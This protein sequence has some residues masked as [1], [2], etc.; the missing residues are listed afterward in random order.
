MIVVK[1]L[2]LKVVL[3]VL[4]LLGSVAIM[5]MLTAPDVSAGSGCTV[6]GALITDTTWSPSV[7]AVYTATGNIIV[8]EGVTLTIAPGTVIRFDTGLGMTIRGT[9][10]AVGTAVSPIT[11]TS[12]S[13][14]PAPADWSGIFFE[15]SSTSAGLDTAYNYVSGSIIQFSTIE[16]AT[17]AIRM[18]YA[19]P[20]IAHNT[21]VNNQRGIL[22]DGYTTLNYPLTIIRDNT[23]TN[24]GGEINGG[25]MYFGWGGRVHIINNLISHNTSTVR[26]GGFF[27]DDGAKEFVI[28][29]NTIVHN[30]TSAGNP[31]GTG[32]GVHA[33]G[34]LTLTNNVIAYNQAVGSQS[35]GGGVYFGGGTVRLVQGNLIMN[36]EASYGAGLSYAI[37]TMEGMTRDNVITNNTAFNQGGGV[38][39][40]FINNSANLTFTHNS[41]YGN[42]ANGVVN[43]VGTT[44]NSDRED[45][46]GIQN[47]WGTTNLATIESHLFHA[48]DDANRALVLIQPILTTSPSSQQTI[49]T[50]GGTFNSGDGVVNLI[51][52]ANV[53]TESITLHYGRLYTPTAALPNNFH[54]ALGFN[55]YAVKV[56]GTAVTRFAQ[57]LTLTIKYPSDAELS[58]MGIDENDLTLVYWDG[59]QWQSAYPCAGCGI[60]TAQNWITVR[61]EHFTEF[62]LV[63]EVPQYPLFLPMIVR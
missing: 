33:G 17:N 51:V 59:A 53:T 8:N 20:Y 7:C 57:P 21:I 25:G 32:A 55:L 41:V 47:W 15:T 6:G 5:E 62:A 34:I 3:F 13:G 14:S 63:A 22:T 56:D 9:L 27:V 52:P 38:M 42:S 50:G 40:T 4:I 30:T 23:I 43:D 12:N 45:I 60:D 11:L 10:K 39:F 29:G 54:Y 18:R 16:Y 48:V 61:L 26:G 19:A 46:N 35:S 1:K 49:S 31:Y 44:D 36:N 58:N 37:T 2:E 24:N 28:S